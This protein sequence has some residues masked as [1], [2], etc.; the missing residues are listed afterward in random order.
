MTALRETW[1]IFTN[2]FKVVLIYKNYIYIY[3]YIYVC[4]YIYI[5]II[6][7]DIYPIVF[8]SQTVVDGEFLYNS[9]YTDI[10]LW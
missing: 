9:F 6:H 8:P 4:V 10:H 3:T 1:I 2:S 7:V 5:Y